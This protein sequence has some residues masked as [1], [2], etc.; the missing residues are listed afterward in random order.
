MNESWTLVIH[1]VSRH[2]IFISTFWRLRVPVD[3][4]HVWKLHHRHNRTLFVTVAVLIE[5][6]RYFHRWNTTGGKYG[7]Q[8]QS[9]VPLKSSLTTQWLGRKA[10]TFCW[11]CGIYYNAREVLLLRVKKELNSL[12]VRQYL[13]LQKIMRPFKKHSLVTITIQYRQNAAWINSII[14]IKRFLLFFLF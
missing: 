4:W 3:L 1:Q 2:Y 13:P 6:L 10:L 5:K 12:L 7:A 11:I 14:C 9:V 8:Q